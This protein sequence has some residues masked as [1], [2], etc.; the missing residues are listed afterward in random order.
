MRL[1][2]YV[3]VST[4][5][6]QTIANQVEKI[7]SYCDLH[8]HEL[9]EVFS[10]HGLSAKNADRPGLRR[11]IKASTSNGVDGLVITKLDRLSRSVRD[12]SEICDLFNR[13]EKALLSVFDHIDTSTAKGR[14]VINLFATIAQWEREEIAERT[15]T[16]MDYLRRQG[17]RIGLH[18]AYGYKIDPD[19]STRVIPCSQEQAI[20]DTIRELRATGMNYSQVAAALNADGHM[21]RAGNPFN[22]S[23]V[24]RLVK[25]L[26]RV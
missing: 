17:R 9:I 24:W 14:M 1:V 20:L 18:A 11:A 2:A 10:D 5:D 15:K 16:S 3:R 26:D 25:N 6:Q 23:G 22:K 12:W 13:R 19:D 7:R 8:D 4:Q 21:N